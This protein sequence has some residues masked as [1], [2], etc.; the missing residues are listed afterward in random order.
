MPRPVRV[1]TP[2]PYQ[3]DLPPSSAT[4]RVTYGVKTDPLPS[5]A[6]GPY[7]TV[8]I[9]NLNPPNYLAAE[10]SIGSKSTEHHVTED[11]YVY[12]GPLATPF[13]RLKIFSLTSLGLSTTLSPFLFIIESN[14]PMSARLALASIAL[15]GSGTAEELEMT[16]LSLTLQPRITKVYDP[17]FLIE[18]RRPLAKWELAEKIALTPIRTHAVGTNLHPAEGQE[19][20]V[21]ETAD[22][23][24]NV[25]GR[26]IVKWGENGVGTCHQ[27]GHVI[28]YFNVH[29]ELLQ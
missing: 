17:S 7:P 1:D 27:V 14:L 26:W 5:S 20:T 28:R 25:M 19:E 13:R 3:L 18:T 8:A 9:F 24:G 23:N 4:L 6:S 16:T 15:D 10:P 22:T 11:S 12:H 29:E 2:C 21:A